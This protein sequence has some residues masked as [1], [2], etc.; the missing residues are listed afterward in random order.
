VDHRSVTPSGIVESRNRLRIYI[1]VQH[2]ACVPSSSAMWFAAVCTVVPRRSSTSFTSHARCQVFH[3]LIEAN[4]D[5]PPMNPRR[6]CKSFWLLLDAYDTRGLAQALSAR[7]GDL[8]GNGEMLVMRTIEDPA[9]PIGEFISAQHSVGFDHFALAMHPLLGLYGV[10]PR[11]PLWQKATHNP[12]SASALL[13][14]AV[15]FS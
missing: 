12:H 4:G 8:L 1:T 15:V 14:P 2:Y 9:N 13:D 11:T 5:E 7:S 3:R 6:V 10:Q